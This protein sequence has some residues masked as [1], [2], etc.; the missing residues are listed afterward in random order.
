M[1]PILFNKHPWNGRLRKAVLA[2]KVT[3]GK[4]QDFVVR[5]GA[6]K[7]NEPNARFDVL[8]KSLGSPSPFSHATSALAPDDN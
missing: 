2:P 1:L 3:C 8:H 6:F 7:G 4:I 5:F